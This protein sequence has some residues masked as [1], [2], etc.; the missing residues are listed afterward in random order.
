MQ[1]CLFLLQIDAHRLA[2]VDQR[3]SIRKAGWMAPAPRVSALQ[4]V[5]VVQNHVYIEAKVPGGF[6]L[7]ANSPFL[8]VAEFESA[9]RC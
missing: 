3:G 2:G 5:A 7:N 1:S 6:A 4:M 9:D 8:E